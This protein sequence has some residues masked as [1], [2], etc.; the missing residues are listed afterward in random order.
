[1]HG[2]VSNSL[3]VYLCEIKDESRL[4]VQDERDLAEAIARGDRDARSRMIQS[5]LKLVVKIARDF[6]GRGLALDDLIS[7]GNL[8]LIRASTEF[9]PRFGTRFST[10]ASYWIKQ[11]IRHALINTTSTIR[12]PAYMVGLLTRWRRAEQALLRQRDSVPSFDDIALVLGLSENQ[13]MMMAQARQ[14]LRLTEVGIETAEVGLRWS[15]EASDR[16]EV[17]SATLQ[18]ADDRRIL[19]ERMQQLEDRENTIIELRYGLNGSEPM[20]LKEIG[21]RLGITREWVRKIEL[22]A[23]RKLGNDTEGGW[24][25]GSSGIPAL[26]R[27]A[28]RP[29]WPQKRAVG[30]HRRRSTVS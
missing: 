15:N 21:L 7:E 24:G 10:Y 27:L 19:R 17:A 29:R 5:N 3:Q 18:D 25:N 30:Q 13:K 4:T 8:G 23:V 2:D 28:R 6:L 12:L 1:M 20:T 11:S 22:R 14:A 26:A 9:Q 16:C